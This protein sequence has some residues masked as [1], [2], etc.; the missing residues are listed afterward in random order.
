MKPFPDVNQADSMHKRT[1]FETIAI[2]VIGHI[3]S[4]TAMR[5]RFLDLSGITPQ[6]LRTG[7]ESAAVQT[8][9]LDFLAG[10]EPDLLACAAGLGLRPEDLVTARDQLGH[11]T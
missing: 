10:H 3:V 7:I 6:E 1:G 8:A 4:D 9:A 5:A 2:L 11:V